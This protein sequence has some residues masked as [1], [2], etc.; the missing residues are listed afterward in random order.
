MFLEGT[1]EKGTKFYAVLEEKV[2]V[3][4]KK[5]Q[6]GLFQTFG[7]GGG[8][9]LFQ[10]TK[11][12]QHPL[13]M[14]N[15]SLTPNVKVTLFEMEFTNEHDCT[16]Y[17]AGVTLLKATSGSTELL[18]DYKHDL[19]KEKDAV[20]SDPSSDEPELAAELPQVRV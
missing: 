6:G 10:K 19:T 13:Y 12:A 17:V 8:N 20:A 7:L 14:M 4:V 9:A 5:K 3:V 18:F 1:H 11:T 15:H 16:M 2:D